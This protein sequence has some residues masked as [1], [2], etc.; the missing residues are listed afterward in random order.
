MKKSAKWEQWY[1]KY[2]IKNPLLFYAF[3]IMGVALF[4]VLSITI[5][6]ENDKTL[7]W[8]IF[9]NAGRSL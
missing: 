7:L 9:A 5:K 4:F 6:L 3:L 2:I 1:V 8:Q